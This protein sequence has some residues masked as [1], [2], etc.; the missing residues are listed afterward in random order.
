MYHNCLKITH[1]TNWFITSESIYIQNVCKKMKEA[2][3]FDWCSNCSFVMTNPA[4]FCAIH[5]CHTIDIYSNQ[6]N[7]RAG[8]KQI[9]FEKNIIIQVYWCSH[10]INILL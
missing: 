4:L 1:A 6:N 8:K 3:T 9:F 5:L 7:I 10:G 2:Q